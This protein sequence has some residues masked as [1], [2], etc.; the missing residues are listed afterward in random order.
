MYTNLIEASASSELNRPATTRASFYRP[1]LD[2]LRFV[3]FFL[4]LLHH[5]L[6]F[7]AY[8]TWSPSPLA[9]LLLHRLQLAA[10]FGLSLFFCLSAYLI[11][12]LL[13]RERDLTGDVSLKDFY[14]RRVLRIWPLYLAVL[15]A[16]FV[17]SRI[18]G[19]PHALV[20]VFFLLLAGNWYSGIYGFAT[21]PI[22]ALWSISVEEQ[23]YL[24][25]PF[26]AKRGGRKLLGIVA[27]ALFALFL[28]T[29]G[30]LVHLHARQETSV[31]TNSF[32]QFNAFAAGLALALALHR[33]PSQ[34][35]SRILQGLLLVASGLLLA[36]A[37]VV[38]NI[39]EAGPAKSWPNLATGYAAVSVG[40]A[41]CIYA[42]I[43][44]PWNPPSVFVYFGKVSYGLYVF[45]STTNAITKRMALRWFSSSSIDSIPYWAAV[46]A[47][48]FL[49]ALLMASLSYRFLERP[50][51]R[52]KDRFAVIHSR[53]I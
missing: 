50:F 18:D 34:N 1:E 36:G 5:T 49:L 9:Q 3:A 21:N 38:L 20:L 53:P 13:L 37:S 41:M 6:P 52:L 32:V 33:R 43:A 11:A 31:W 45:H 19:E 35:V 40:S 51:L 26:F 39:R 27:G 30:I 16:A 14:I 12:T 24:F 42:F 28:I 48:S 4:V 8:G 25:I 10:G 23:F 47:I 17:R 7:S 29:V 22:T 46:L 44:R 15:L 2:V